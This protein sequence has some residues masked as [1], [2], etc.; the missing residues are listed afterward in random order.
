[1]CGAVF[2]KGGRGMR[3]CPTDKPTSADAKGGL[4]FRAFAT[5]CTLLAASKQGDV[6]SQAR[7]VFFLV[8]EDAGGVISR[9]ELCGFVATC[10]D[11]NLLRPQKFHKRLLAKLQSMS[12][13]TTLALGIRG[14]PGYTPPQ[15]CYDQAEAVTSDIME[16]ADANSDGVLDEH[17]FSKHVA[18]L[19]YAEMRDQ[20]FSAPTA[21]ASGTVGP[22]CDFNV[23]LR[24]VQEE[25]RRNRETRSRRGGGGGGGGGGGCFA[26]GTLV[27]MAGGGC[28]PIEDVRPGEHVAEGGLVRASMAFAAGEA[29]PLYM[30]RGVTVTA[31]HAVRLEG[32]AGWCRAVDAPGATLASVR[33]SADAPLVYDLITARHRLQ[34]VGMHGGERAVTTFADYE[35]TDDSEHDLRGFLRALAREDRPL[36]V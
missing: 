14:D 3:L 28:K 33:V 18:P 13:S 34:L 30:Y 10:L 2:S 27:A 17:E 11:A 29:A 12:H 19:I 9:N 15:W 24:Q 36:V 8:D 23:L 35:E 16:L 5:L 1:M 7:L 32:G 6:D 20:G 4:S 22:E 25:E 31:D 21:L 26:R